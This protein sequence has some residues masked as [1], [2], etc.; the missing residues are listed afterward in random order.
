[1]TLN[2]RECSVAEIETSSNIAKLLEEY[3]AESS[4]SGLPH[5]SAKWE[6]YKHLEIVKAIHIFGAFYED[7]LIGFI[8][9]L[10]PV[11]PHYGMQVAVA[12]S[13]FV[14]ETY[15]KTGAG[16]KLL[17]KAEKHA[18]GLGSPGL[19]VSAPSGGDLAEV[20]P[21]VGYNETNQVFFKG[22]NG[23]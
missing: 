22:F 13:F 12:E 17:R 23:E 6:M 3:A 7:T 2:I 5:P 20:L 14:S 9:F 4:L 15:R 21:H 10:A 16:L 19:L 18:Q 1:M 8:V 11:L